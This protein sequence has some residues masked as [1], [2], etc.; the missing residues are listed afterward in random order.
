[1]LCFFL[2]MFTFVLPRVCSVFFLT[3]FIFHKLN[4][5]VYNLSEILTACYI[6]KKKLSYSVCD[7]YDIYFIFS[8]DKKNELLNAD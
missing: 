8:D 6:W 4:G 1:M 2:I 5:I 3:H 7:I